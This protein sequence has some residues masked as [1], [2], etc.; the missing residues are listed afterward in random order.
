MTIRIIKADEFAPKRDMEYGTREQNEAVRRILAEVRD[1]GDE[2]LIRFTEQ[3][4]RV[5]ITS[6]RVGEEEIREAYRHVDEAF[7]QALRRARDNIRAFHEKQKRSSW[8][9]LQDDGSMLGQIIRPLRRVGV[10]VPGGTAAYPSSVLMNVIPAQVAGVK[11]IAMATPPASGGEAGINPHILVAAAEAGVT[12]VYRVGGAQAIAALAYGTESIPAVD[13]ICGPG[14]IYVALAKQAVY[15]V[16]DIDSIAGPTDIAVLADASANPVYV[17]ADMLSQAEH[18]VMAQAIL[19]T[20]NVKLAEEVREELERQLAALPRR[21]IAG[22]SLESR[23]A[24]IL[25]SDMREGAEVV[26]RIAPEHLEIMTA[27]PMALLPEIVNAGAI[28]LGPYSS[29]PV[30]DY[31]AGPNH[32]LPT[33]GTARFSSPLNVDDFVKKSSLISYSKRA[34]LQ[35]ARDIMTLARHEGFEGHARAIQVRLE[36]NISPDQEG[37]NER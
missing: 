26:N 35:N 24:I 9:D 19:V 5:R 10:Y 12:E 20:D 36:Q 11:E 34:L 6:L 30:G 21:D 3:F 29:E 1:Q 4:D 31:F 13:K 14:N 32:I 8:I 22:E 2:A 23:G 28:F 17:A 37:K 27:D 7:L 25:V 18:D 33:N 15:G 16:V